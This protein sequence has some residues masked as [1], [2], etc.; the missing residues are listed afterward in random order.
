MSEILTEAFK[1]LRSFI[2]G[3]VMT[4]SEKIKA[5]VMLSNIRCYTDGLARNNDREIERISNE[6][7][8]ALKSEFKEAYSK[9]AAG[10]KNLE[11]HKDSLIKQLSKAYESNYE[12]IRRLAEKDNTDV[13]EVV[14]EKDK[15]ILSH[16]DKVK[17]GNISFKN[18][19]DMKLIVELY[20]QGYGAGRIVKQLKERGIVI[21][22]QTVVNRLTRIGLWGNR[23]KWVS[24]TRTVEEID[25]IKR[26]SIDIDS[27]VT[28]VNN[29]IRR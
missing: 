16:I 23:E 5:K 12:L 2:D 26:H 24:T 29:Y 4:E 15:E 9:L 25:Y 13:V 17:D 7:R 14:S 21:T 20:M 3:S 18:D 11:V 19:V 28:V 6:K 10:Y 1:E 22:R 27:L 8:D